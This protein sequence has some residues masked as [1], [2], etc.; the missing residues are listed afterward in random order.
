VRLA[1]DLARDPTASREPRTE[2]FRPSLIVRESTAP[3]A[4]RS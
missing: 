1:I 4:N 2:V 3:P